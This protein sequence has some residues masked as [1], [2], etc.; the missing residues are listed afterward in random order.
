MIPTHDGHTTARLERGILQ[1]VVLTLG[2]LMYGWVLAPVAVPIASV[3]VLVAYG[4]IAHVGMRIVCRRA[5][6]ILRA[7]TTCGVLAAVL[8]VPSFL[9]ESTDEG[10]VFGMV[11]VFARSGT[12]DFGAWTARHLTGGTFSHLLLGALIAAAL[13]GIAG[14]LIAGLTRLLEHVEGH[15]RMTRS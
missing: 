5:P 9:V 15:Q 10:I 4:L 6:G 13:G 1:G 3:G 14:M 12:K 8:F 2:L 11:R 7:I